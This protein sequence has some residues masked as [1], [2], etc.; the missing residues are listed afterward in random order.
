MDALAVELNE[1]LK[2]SSIYDLMSDFREKIF[3][4]QKV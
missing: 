4:F 3:S 1:K 2:G